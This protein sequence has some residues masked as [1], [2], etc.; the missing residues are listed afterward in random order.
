MVQWMQPE[1]EDYKERDAYLLRLQNA[2]DAENVKPLAVVEPPRTSSADCRPCRQ[3]DVESEG[4]RVTVTE[5]QP[6]PFTD[7]VRLQRPGVTRQNWER[8]TAKTQ[9]NQAATAAQHTSS[10]ATV[11]SDHRLPSHGSYRIVSMMGKARSAP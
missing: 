6:R 11:R 5:R 1:R 3:K 2:E 10:D 8:V 4:P 7:L 9:Q